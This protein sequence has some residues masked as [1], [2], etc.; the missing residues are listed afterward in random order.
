MP[1]LAHETSRQRA[2]RDIAM[3][4]AV[5]IG[6]LALGAFV[7]ALVVR[8]LGQTEYGEWS[9][10]FVALVLVGYFANFG[11]QGIALRESARH[12]EQEHEWIGAV[13]FLRLMALAPMMLISLA[14]VVLLHRSHAMLLAGV[15]L[16]VSMPFDGVG[17]LGLL[18]QLR[19]DNRVPMLVLTLRSVL[20]G[21]AVVI[22]HIEDGGMVA[23]AI[24][25]AATN[26]VGSI[27]QA[28]AALKLD[29]RWPRPSRKRVR[30]VVRAGLPIGIAGVLVISYARID[31]VIVFAIAGSGAAGLYGAVYTLLEQAHFVPISV[32]TTLAPVM[33]ASW[34]ADRE[35]LLRATRMTAELLAITSLGGLAFAIVASEPVIRLI[36]GSEFVSAAPALPVL[37]AA[38]IFIS[39]GYLN[40]NLLVTLG[41]QGRMLSISL[42]ALVVNLGGN[43]I[44]VPTVGFMGAA[45]MTM[46]TEVIVCVGSLAVILRTLEMPLPKPGRIGRTVLA[47]ALLTAL[48]EV[49]SV[50]D[51]SLVVLIVATCVAYPA[52]LFALRA[53]GRDD[54]QALVRRTVS[55]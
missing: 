37:A 4:I 35:R 46:A 23:L 33:A 21:V 9:T 2:G 36:F 44:L 42:V 51:A 30:A 43:L 15:I 53:F 1:T 10:T 5:R 27:V 8:T 13:M 34:P 7:T 11:M 18:F 55:I 25:M 26:A 50:A 29:V 38:F 45:W 41:L 32:L 48:L 24:A 31:Q 49:L 54:F 6:N 52:L 14:T 40:G 47:A 3:Q 17:A 19:V 22:I 39:F 20:W 16:T 28:V 12:P